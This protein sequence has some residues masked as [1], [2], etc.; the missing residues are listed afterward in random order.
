MIIGDGFH[1]N[2]SLE[3][4]ALSERKIGKLESLL[5]CQESWLKSEWSGWSGD[6]ASND[7]VNHRSSL[8]VRLS[9]CCKTFQHFK[10][11][12]GLLWPGKGGSN[13]QQEVRVLI[14]QAKLT[15]TTTRSV[16]RLSESH[17]WPTICEQ[18]KSFDDNCR[19]FR[20]ARCSI[21]SVTTC[22]K[23]TRSSA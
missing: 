7:T 20:G 6:P 18:I 16:E 8:T 12:R 2:S 22:R 11:P 14:G 21:G 3:R 15:K 13:A 10:A 9:N 1:L 4:Q 19:A 17:N 23:R 5:D